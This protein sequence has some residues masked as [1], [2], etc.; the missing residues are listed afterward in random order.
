MI[1][2]TKITAGSMAIQANDQEI[3]HR[4]RNS[5]AKPFNWYVATA[6]V[7]DGVMAA[8]MM[9]RTNGACWG[10]RRDRRFS[11]RFSRA[12]HGRK[13]SMGGKCALVMSRF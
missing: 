7:T 13:K 10:D 11:I 6:V 1:G 5:V 3:T 12:E 4:S 8:L 9:P 2:A